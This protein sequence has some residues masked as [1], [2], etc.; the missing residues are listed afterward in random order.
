[1]SPETLQAVLARAGA[2]QIPIKQLL[3]CQILVPAPRS[4]L[5]DLG[6]Q[7]NALASWL[8]EEAED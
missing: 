3:G 5:Q 2:G 8:Y 1:L 7:L 4:H 6:D